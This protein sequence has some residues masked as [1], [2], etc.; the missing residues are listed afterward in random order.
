MWSPGPPGPSFKCRTQPAAGSRGRWKPQH[1]HGVV[2][3]NILLGELQQHGVIE[4]LADAYVLAQALPA[5]GFDHEF[6][7]QVRSRLWLQRADDNALV[8]RITGHNLP[9]VEDRQGKGLPL[10]VSPQISLK[11]KRINGGDESFDGVERGA[12]DGCI[13]SHMPPAPGQDGVHSGDTIRRGLD[14]HKVVRLHQT[15]SGHE[16]G[17]IDDSPCRG[18][19]L[20]PAPVQGLLGNHCIQDLKLDISNH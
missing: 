17:R 13:L 16:E 12:W 14:L 20:A 1:S 8:Q 18:D 11:A 2:E 5:T 9:M 10:G 15:R 19:D 4:E 3:H 7:G 6:P